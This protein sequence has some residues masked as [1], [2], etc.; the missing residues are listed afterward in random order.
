MA[1]TSAVEHW[2]QRMKTAIVLDTWLLHS[3]GGH[4]PPSHSNICHSTI[5]SHTTTNVFCLHC[6]DCTIFIAH[7][8]HA[9]QPT[10]WTSRHICQ[11][12]LPVKNWSL[13]VL[14]FAC[15][16]SR[17]LRVTGFGC[18][19]PGTGI[20]DNHTPPILSA[21][22]Q[23][24]DPH[25]HLRCIHCSIIDRNVETYSPDNEPR[26]MQKVANRFRDNEFLTLVQFSSR[27]S[28]NMCHLESFAFN[29]VKA[30]HLSTHRI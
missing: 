26:A 18:I 5:L 8:R 21:F 2:P 14:S 24:H 10:C 9:S 19:F 11:P 1:H 16:R 30:V 27:I 23:R 7:H 12:V 6:V 22:L 3:N 29:G 4:R 13:G 15:C 25:I 17:Q 20:F 28:N